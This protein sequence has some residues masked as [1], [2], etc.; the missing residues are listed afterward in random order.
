MGFNLYPGG[1]QPCR[2]ILKKPRNKRL[3]KLEVK[4]FL[5]ERMF[6]FC[7]TKQEPFIYKMLLESTHVSGFSFK[8]IGIN[9][10]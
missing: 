4:T 9:V 3:L 10:I 8:V 5:F 7:T 6:L 1:F 2:K